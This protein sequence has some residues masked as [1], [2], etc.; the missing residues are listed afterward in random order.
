[1]SEFQTNQLLDE[2]GFPINPNILLFSSSDNI[3][4]YSFGSNIIHYNLNNNI[5]TFFQLSSPNEIVTLKFIDNNN[6]ILLSIHNNSNP[7]INIWDLYNFNKIFNQDISINNNYGIN[8]PISNIF[9]EKIRNNLF[10]IM[11]SSSLTCNYILYIL[12]KSEGKY[13]LEHFSSQINQNNNEINEQNI[14]I[15]FKFFLNS[16]KCVIILKTSLLFCEIDFSNKS[17]EI[18]KNINYNFNILPN[19]LSISNEYNLISFVSSK[20]NCLVYDINCNNRAKI[21]PYNQD[22][23][24]ISYFNQDSIYLGTTNGKIFVYKI[25]DYKLKYYINYNKIYFFKKEFQ[26]NNKNK[27]DLDNAVY[28]NDFYGPTIEYLNCDENNNKIFIK[29][30][31]NSIIL[32]PISFIIDKNNKYIN[33][34]IKGSCPL[35]FAYNHSQVITDIEFFPLSHKERVDHSIL[36]DKIQTTFYT[37]SKDQTIIKYYINH[38]ENKIYNQFYDFSNIFFNNNYRDVNINQNNKEFNNYF[39]VIKFHPKQKN[40]LYLGDKKGNIK[41]LDIN[42][43]DIIYNQFI[44]ELYSINT[45]SFNRQGNLMCIG[46]ETGMEV[47]YYINSKNNINQKFEKYLILNNH[48]FSPEEIE[49]RKNNNHILS[50]SYFFAHNKFNE[51]KIIYMKTG[52]SIEYSLII[53]KNNNYKEILNIINM[54]H[55]ILDIKTHKGENYIIILDDNLLINIYDLISKNN[56]GIIDLNG[57]IKNAYNI[58]ID[59]SGL[60][61]SLLCQLKDNNRERSDIIL[62]EIGTGNVHSF[63]SGLNPLIKT[64]FDYSGKYLITTGINGEI[65][66]LG[67]DEDAIDSIR[68]VIQEINNNPKFLEQYKIIFNNN[69]GSFY[70]NNFENNYINNKF[71]SE[72]DSKSILN[73]KQIILN[74]IRKNKDEKNNNYFNKVKNNSINYNR[75]KNYSSKFNFSEFDNKNKTLNNINYKSYSSSRKNNT[76]NNQ[77]NKS[78]RDNNIF[79]KNQNYKTKISNGESPI[80]YTPQTSKYQNLNTKNSNNSNLYSNTINSKNRFNYFELNKFNNKPRLSYINIIKN[81]FNS[82]NHFNNKNNNTLFSSYKIKLNSFL[83]TKTN[84]DFK[85]INKAIT[86]IMSKENK[87]KEKPIKYNEENDKEKIYSKNNKFSFSNNLINN[88]LSSFYSNETDLYK[89]KDLLNINN[90]RINQS[91]LN[92]RNISDSINSVFQIYQKDYHKKYPEPKDIDDIENCYY[93]NNNINNIIK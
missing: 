88:N 48:Y 39:T 40:Y 74:N 2:L 86:E 68:N 16:Q 6:K 34:K 17:C 90:K 26:I 25:S 31:D 83:K 22:D 44:G 10:I 85:K 4:I 59:V 65:N 93:I 30:G 61:L 82:T 63:I 5:K 37:C 77:S 19:S 71:H 84:Y 89:S 28:E 33:D 46:Y 50:Y 64:K 18:K 43:K 29:M 67:L 21:S 42:K 3:L 92:E 57:Q 9:V 58:D 11:I 51:N 23:F 35:L 73:Q 15:G 91:D 56:I 13:H 87:E 36:I 54:N 78:F 38:K 1:M 75:D 8:F 52:K 66:L 47:L 41:I 72:F 69:Q 7:L 20:G 55:I 60:Y 62:F 14:I 79:N 49:M 76:F 12:Y 27:N 24:S 80:L 70:N 53:E 81:P 45:L 32:C